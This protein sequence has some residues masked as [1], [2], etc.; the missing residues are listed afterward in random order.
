MDPPFSDFLESTTDPNI[1]YVGANPFP[2]TPVRRKTPPPLDPLPSN[3]PAHLAALEIRPDGRLGRRDMLPMCGD[4]ANMTT[5]RHLLFTLEPGEKKVE[6]E[7]DSRTFSV[8]SFQD[9]R[10]GSRLIDFRC[11]E[12]V[13]LHVE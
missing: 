12:Y 5:P 11:S 7:E 9:S 13:H 10:V 8:A 2:S 4:G 1:C 6:S 3:R